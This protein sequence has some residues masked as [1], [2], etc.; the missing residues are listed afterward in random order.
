MYTVTVKIAA[1]GAIYHEDG[2]SATGHMW[3]SISN[4]N[5][6]ESYGFAPAKDSMPVWVGAIKTTDD[7]NYKPTYYTGTIVIDFN[8]Y[9]KLQQFGDISKLD[10]NPFDFSSFYNGL[11]N[12]CIDYTWKALNIIGMNPSDFE[13]QIWPTKNADDADA[14]LYKYLMG[15][16]SGWD[17]SLSKS[18]G[19]DVIYG[20]KA[21]DDLRSHNN[22]DA[23]YGGD[24]NDDIYGNSNN[25]RLFGGT[26][27]DFIDGGWGNDYIEGNDGNDDLLGF[28]GSDTIYGGFGNDFI[29]GGEL[30]DKLFGGADNDTISGDAGDDYIEGGTG[31]DILSGGT[32]NDYL[33]GGDG[34]DT[35][36]GGADLDTL[37]GGSGDDLLYGNSGDD[38]LVAGANEDILVGGSGSDTLL[39]QAG[40]DVLAGGNSLDDL[41]S[42]KEFD[43]LSGGT[44]FDTYL[45]SHRD[46]IND[47]DLNGLIMFNNKSLSGK[48]T[49]VDENTYEDDNFTYTL[50]GSNMIVVDKNLG[51]YITIENF[52]FNSNGLG[53]SFDGDNDKKDVE[54]YVGDATVTEGGTLEFTVGIDNTLDKD[55][56]LNVESYFTGSA[57]ADDLSSPISGT[58]TIK[59]GDPSGTFSIDTVDDTTPEPTENFTF[60]VTG[61]EYLGDDT[62]SILIKNA[63]EGTIED[64][65]KETLKIEVSNESMQEQNGLMT[66][67]VSLIGTLE[68]GET[69]TVNLASYDGTA[70]Y[71]QDDYSKTTGSVT[72]TSSNSTQPFSVPIKEDDKKESDEIFYLAPI[73]TSGYAGIREVV[74]VNAGEGTI[75]DDDVNGDISIDVS[76]VSADEGDSGTQSATVEVTLSDK[77]SNAILI[78]MSNGEVLQIP[79]G[80]KNATATVTWGPGA[81]VDEIVDSDAPIAISVADFIYPAPGS[82]VVGDYVSIIDDGNIITGEHKLTNSLNF[83]KK[84]VA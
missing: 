81:P 37:M 6:T 23:I 77:L 69:L 32:G 78:T 54:I 13:G 36:S 3:Y 50:S 5:S 11:T 20:S 83:N 84:E 47:V 57:G 48:K 33:D 66:F 16:T 30:H 38:I 35:L 75:E 71:K 63:G 52:N 9:E 2:T 68:Q 27:D 73:S 55:L 25:E 14:T 72:F 67:S 4:G 43:Y 82:V 53:I 56:I 12:S 60:A 80:D 39:G 79:A 21:D 18:D 22:T 40:N 7:D 24:G 74:L 10:G 28:N 76:S 8:Q 49:K 31:H 1:R 51:E 34:N 65:D 46:V 59:A 45:V 26:G 61:Y 58:I 17:G 15:N 44:G 19:Y 41:Y 70:S 62:N 29:D 42:E 64:N